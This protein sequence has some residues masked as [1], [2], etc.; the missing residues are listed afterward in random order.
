M[1]ISHEDLKTLEFT[2]LSWGVITVF[3]GT[4][5][6]GMSLVPGKI[7]NL[8]EFTLEFIYDLADTTL[9]GKEH[10]RPF[11]PLFVS[12]FLFILVSNLLGLIPGFMA[13]TANMNT[14]FALSLIVFIYYHYLAFKKHGFGYIKSFFGAIKVSEMPGFM[15]GP[16]AIFGYVII[17]IIEVLSHLTRPVS[18]GLR[19]FGNMFAKE[20]LLVILPVLI[21]QFM[22]FPNIFLKTVL[23]SMPIIL[24]PLVILLGVLISL[25]QAA[26]FLFL[27]II[28]IAGAIQ[29]EE[30]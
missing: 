11:Y 28:Y 3:C 18:L 5:L 25:I 24:A 2:L 4:A 20:T 17:P 9:G 6:S 21:M 14:T 7:Q 13:P 16:M 19:L 26:V 22:A 27:T 30:H 12:I 10:A 23:S 29:S 1:H 8:L 15:K